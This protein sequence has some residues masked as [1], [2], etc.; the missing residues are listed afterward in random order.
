MS[1]K[2]LNSHLHSCLPL[3]ICKKPASPFRMLRASCAGCLGCIIERPNLPLR[4]HVGRC[5]LLPPPKNLVKASR[6]H[7][8]TA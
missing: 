2:R 1:W 3:K 6:R 8:V 7:P 5:Y 4:K